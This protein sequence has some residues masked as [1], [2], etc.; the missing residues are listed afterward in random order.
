MHT[1]V[2]HCAAVRQA[3]FSPDGCVLAAAGDDGAI[4]VWDRVGFTLLQHYPGH[5][6][7][8]FSIAFHP[9]SCFLL[10]AGEDASLRMWDLRGEGLLFTL[11]GHKREVRGA[12][13]SPGG[14][15]FATVG[16]DT[17]VLVWQSNWTD[18]DGGEGTGD[19]AAALELNDDAIAR[20]D[21]SSSSTNNGR[22]YGG[23]NDAVDAAPTTTT[24]ATSTTAR[25]N[26]GVGQPMPRNWPSPLPYNDASNNTNPRGLPLA[27]R[28]PSTPSTT[29]YTSPL[30][31]Q[32]SS[33]YSAPSSYASS[34]MDASAPRDV[35]DAGHGG[36]GSASR[37][38]R[39]VVSVIVPHEVGGVGR[40]VNLSNLPVPSQSNDGS[41]LGD[42]SGTTTLAAA[43]RV[44]ARA[45]AP[46]RLRPA[47]P[48]EACSGGAPEGI[49]KGKAW[50]AAA[51]RTV[52]DEDPNMKMALHFIVQ[53]LESITATL[54]GLEARVTAIEAGAQRPST[55]P[56]GKPRGL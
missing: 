22:A 19:F 5:D 52:R 18:F 6:T 2:D 29:P 30:N 14:D 36:G 27:A 17:Q 12:A 35:T 1:F 4:N 47:Q 55:A 8:I 43:R 21:A 7:R 40:S 33:S 31:S 26:G 45:T 25:G 54:S 23:R 42:R 39:S 15:F 41:A 32:R 49:E 46:R 9:S 37:R 51:A 24:V 20:R 13:F 3:A 11:F 50:R 28:R 10:S 38:R 44:V 48:D 34:S 16:E 56:G 53:Q